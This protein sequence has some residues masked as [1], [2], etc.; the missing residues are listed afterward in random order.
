MIHLTTCGTRQAGV[1]FPQFPCLGASV[2]PFF[3][4]IAILVKIL[5]IILR[6]LA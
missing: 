6:V 1:D 4:H 2:L 5:L 3:L